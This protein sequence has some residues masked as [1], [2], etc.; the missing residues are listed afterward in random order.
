[1][2]GFFNH[3]LTNLFFY[4]DAQRMKQ[5]LPR[6]LEKHLKKK[7]YGLL[8]YH[9]PECGKV[10]KCSSLCKFNPTSFLP[11]MLCYLFKRAKAKV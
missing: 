8:S 9:Q 1:M 4:K 10:S 6:E 3:L 2:G 11:L 5:A 7:C